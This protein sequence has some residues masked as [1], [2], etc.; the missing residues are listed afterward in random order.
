[1]EAIQSINFNKAII[2]TKILD[3]SSLLVVDQDTSVRFLKLEDLSVLNGFKANIH[4]ERYSSS[5]V[6][7]SNDAKYFISTTS[8]AKEA[9]LYNTKTKKAIAK[10]DR[11]SGEV[12]CVAIDPKERF[13]FAGGDD[14][15]TYGVDIK[16]GKLVFTL[17]NHIDTINDIAFNPSGQWVATASYDKKISVFNLAMM[18]PKFRLKA[19]SAPVMKLQFLNNFRLFSVDKNSSA[20]IWNI[21][22]GKVISRMQ[23]IHDDVTSVVNSIDN[24]FLFLGT[25]LGYVLVYDLNTYE[26]VDGKYI[27]LKDT[28]TTLSFEANNQHLIVGTKNGDLQVYDIYDGEKELVELLKEKKYAQMQ[29]YSEKNLLLNYTKP[30]QIVEDLW[31]KTV[32]KAKELLGNS[33]RDKALAIFDTFKDI[34]IKNQHIQK[35]M[36]EYLEFD[37]FVILVKQNK[38][39]LAYSLAS[40]YPAYKDSELYEAVEARW[41]KAF[42]LAQKYLLDASSADKA[43]EIL[44]PY[45]GIVEKSKLINELLTNIKVYKVFRSF[46][47]KKDFK[48]AFNLLD[49]YPFLEES[50]EYNSIMNY[51]D[52]IYIKAHELITTGDTHSALRLLK[53]LYDFQDYS[54]EAYELTQEIEYRE[55][56]FQALEEKNIHDAYNILSESEILEE[57]PEGIK[58]IEAWENDVDIANAYAAKGKVSGID[59]VLDKYKKISSKYRS[60]AIIYSWCYITQL[61]IAIKQKKDK[62]IIEKG[63]RNHLS[64]FG[65]QENIIG[66]FDIFKKYYPDTK[67]DLEQQILGS[68]EMWRPSMI[69]KSILD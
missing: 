47:A 52:K 1:M 56:F 60:L 12:S 29:E 59:G 54:K 67:L 6:Y 48:M 17:P 45:R 57:T 4:H 9:R 30:H 46:I 69:V 27:K 11:H 63:I 31:K 61:E 23:G 20:I 43:K 25:K 39:A 22:T 68:L 16:S 49:K 3:D 65:L 21:Q 15:R 36:K 24:K 13:M 8:D 55:K 2:Y 58:L 26:L 53:I 14:G 18:T 41:K 10:V 42:K 40:K 19:H 33:Q 32:A 34:P 51:A 50:A 5:M 37:K 62:E 66:F 35:L 44:A 64:Y 28:I 38:L 7:F